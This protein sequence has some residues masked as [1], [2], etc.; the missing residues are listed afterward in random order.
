M[1]QDDLGSHTSEVPALV[2]LMVRVLPRTLADDVEV[3]ALREPAVL[4]RAL[5]GDSGGMTRE[6]HT[7]RVLAG[8]LLG[9]GFTVHELAAPGEGAS[10]R[11]LFAR[12][13]DPAKRGPRLAFAAHVGAAE[14]VDMKGAVAGFV[15]A[16]AR[17]LEARPHGLAGTVSLLVTTE[18]SDVATAGI[19]AVTDWLDTQNEM[20]D[21]CIVGAP[22]SRARFGDVVKLGCRGQLHGVVTVQGRAGSTTC[23]ELADNPVSRLLKFLGRLDDAQ[24]D[25]GSSHFPRSSLA[26]TTVDVNNHASHLIPAAASAAFEIRYNDHHTRASLESWL[27]RLALAQLGA[28]HHLELCGTG[29]TTVKPPGGL[30]EVMCAAI[31]A[32]TGQRPA[33]DTGSDATGV[34]L[35]R[36]HC[37]MVEF[38]P[39]RETMYE[40][41]EQ[42]A[43]AELE[44]LTS[45]Y[46]AVLTQIMAEDRPARGAHGRLDA[47]LGTPGRIAPSAVFSSI[48]MG[49]RVDVPA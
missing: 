5:L 36:R 26:I 14:V 35:M 34:R 46:Q 21:L 31:A 29:D 44:Q 13:G 49:P 43:L 23:P 4:A 33:I 27:R 41:A 1:T 2:E 6:A 45:V 3:A 25:Q 38:G 22:T 19:A 30:S 40:A 32:V 7:L 10:R 8:A 12:L 48:S 18:A 11:T 39:R 42:D 20:P 17:A 47:G 37:P 28:A 16:V 15:A 24:L 9:L